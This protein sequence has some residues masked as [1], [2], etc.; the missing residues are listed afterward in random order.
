MPLIFRIVVLAFSGASLGLS[1]TLYENIRRVNTDDDPDN[2][3]AP[4]ASTYMALV[5]GSVAIPYVLYV[6]WDEY[7]SKPYVVASILPTNAAN[8]NTFL[9]WDSARPSPKRPF[10]SVTF[11]SSY[12]RRRTSHSHSTL[13]STDD[14]LVTQSFIVRSALATYGCRP[15]ARTIL[16]FATSRKPSEAC[17]SSVWWLGWRPSAYRL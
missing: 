13:S 10:S 11:I 7:M 14:G 5:V 4:R 12:F 6:T 9:V 8:A 17:L 2:Q 3:C 15:H 16:R 1:A